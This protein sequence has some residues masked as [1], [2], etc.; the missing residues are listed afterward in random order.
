MRAPLL[1][2]VALALA[3]SGSAQAR[4]A[5]CDRAC[6]IALSDRYV[7]AM[8]AKAPK[9][10]PWAEVVRF[11]E[12]GVPMM[13]GDALW[14][15]I[16][17]R[18]P[19]PLHAA[20]PSSGQVAW[21]GTVEEHGELTH[22]AL[23]LR[24]VD[25][26]IAEAESQIRRKGG[27][28]PYGEKVSAADPLFGAVL[29]KAQRSARKRLIALV[30]G[31]FDSVQRNDGKLHTTFAPDCM[32]RDNGETT[33][34]GDKGPAAL[35]QGC[36]AQIRIGA[37]AATERVRAR[38]FPI[39]DEE[40]GVVVATG[41]MD[42]P[43]RSATFRTTDGREH[44]TNTKYPESLAFVQAFRISDG[45]IQRIET[46]FTPVPYLMPSPWTK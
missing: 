4:D 37:F 20:D 45:A 38:A 40:R 25:G 31:Y 13:I 1:A 6:L 29:P 28:A 10:L 43:V 39:V 17:A 5:G 30:N 16:T 18:T 34:S 21:F 42:H 9:T 22:L 35:A 2:L 46:V 44:P 3:A 7:D 19:A 32:R 23:R 26:R 24:V 41:L 15:S 11:S 8:I 12:D 33:T 36:E 14:A 27:W